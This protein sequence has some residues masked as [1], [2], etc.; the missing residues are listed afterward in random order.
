M[1]AIAAVVAVLA[2]ALPVLAG[3]PRHTPNFP[4]NS[5]SVDLTSLAE[6]L[7]LANTS[8]LSVETVSQLVEGGAISREEGARLLKAL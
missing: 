1:R 2:L 8:T 3:A 7:K 5:T 4:V 6:V